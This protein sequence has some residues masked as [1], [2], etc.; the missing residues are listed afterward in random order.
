[1]IV[2]VP[3]DTPVTTP[4]ASTVA[5]AVL[6]DDQLISVIGALE[7][8]T[9]ALRV[10]VEPLFTDVAPLIAEIPVTAGPT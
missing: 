7:G 1:M 3:A 6:D 2:A 9:E 4:E 10:I 5:T 8:V